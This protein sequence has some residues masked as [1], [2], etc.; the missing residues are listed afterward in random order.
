M[1]TRKE[2][3]EVFQDTMEWI[4]KE[5]KLGKAV[6]KAKKKTKIFYDND[7]P[8]FYASRLRDQK[9]S[10]S[11]DRSFQAAM[12]L[13]KEFSDSRIVVLNFA[14]AFRPG[15]GVEA[16][17]SAQEECLCRCSTLYPLLNRNYLIN[18]FYDYHEEQGTDNASDALV[19][20]EGVVICK[21]DTDI[22]QRMPDEDWVTVDVITG[23][24]PDLNSYPNF[25][26][27]E[28]PVARPPVV[29]DRFG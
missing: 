19:Y 13:K 28:S 24:A 10:V 3:I 20:T 11:T 8:A 14:N 26:L 18:N 12:R 6:E 15:G 21:T 7:Y 29:S 16:G 9:V 5:P 1:S 4:R 25:V 27:V 17:A 2:R 23:A 22:P